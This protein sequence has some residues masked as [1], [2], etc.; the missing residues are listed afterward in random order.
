MAPNDPFI[1]ACFEGDL[2][3]VERFIAN[4]TLTPEDFEEGL[5][6]A[7]EQSHADVISTLFKA[8]ATIT[9]MALDSLPGDVLEQEPLVLRQYLDHGLDPNARTSD[10]TPV[11]VYVTSLRR[12]ERL[13]RLII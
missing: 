12:G 8:G 3:G 13:S 11:L 2:E 4:E 7:T 1:D 9:E 10:G 6:A 5:A